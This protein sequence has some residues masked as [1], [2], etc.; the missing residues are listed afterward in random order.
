NHN[1]RIIFIPF[2]T[3]ERALE[4]D[5]AAAR[6][7]LSMMERQEQVTLLADTT[8]PEIIKGLLSH[9]QLVVGMRLHSLIFAAGTGV[10]AVA[11]VY[12]PKVRNF[13][14]TLGLSAF[15]LELHS[16]SPD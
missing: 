11:L 10:P 1:A 9:C 13:M 8:T 2:Q 3:L 6:D 15:A 7:I 12:D 14:N 4:N 5:H 16:F